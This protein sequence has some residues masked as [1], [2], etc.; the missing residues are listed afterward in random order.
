MRILLDTNILLD[1]CDADR[2]P[3]HG[4]CL[5]LLMS[6]VDMGIELCVFAG[7]LKD[8]YYV[9]RKKYGEPAAR[10]ATA[11]LLDRFE[12]LPLLVSTLRAAIDSDEPDFED[13]LVRAAAESNGVSA[14]VSR[15][16]AAF[17][18]SMV[19]SYSPQEFMRQIGQE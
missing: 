3:F 19:P 11:V 15:D 9:L 1:Y 12:V 13:G 16:A 14:I 10:Q 18:M 8:V 5:D 7:S 6:C 4:E 17:G 2:T